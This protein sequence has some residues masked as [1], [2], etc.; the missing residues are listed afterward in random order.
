MPCTVLYRN[1]ITPNAHQ[2]FGPQI[3]VI[4]RKESHNSKSIWE[5]NA[6]SPMP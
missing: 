5:Q 6:D 1:A 3:S 2:R 4:S